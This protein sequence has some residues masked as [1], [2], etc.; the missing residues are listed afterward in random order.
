[1]RKLRLWFRSTS[2]RVAPFQRACW[3][4]WHQG[5][6]G[7]LIAPTGSGKT[8][9]VLG[10]PLVNAAA[11][12]TGPGLRLLWITPLRALA[13]DTQRQISEAAIGMGLD[14][15]VLRRTGDSGGTERARVA[16]GALEALVTTPESL[17]L[18]LSHPDIVER[19][20][21]VETIVVDE[22]HELLGNKRGV[23]LQLSLARIRASKPDVRVWG[24]SATIGNPAQALRVLLGTGNGTLIQAPTRRTVELVT[25]LPERAQRFP[26]GGHLGLAQLPRVLAAINA[27]RTTLVFTNTRSQAELWHQALSA[28]WTDDGAQLAIHHGSIDRAERERVETQLANGELRAVV[29]TSSLDLGVDFAAVDLV[30][31][32]GSPRS[33]ARLMQRAG[34]S[35]HRPGARSRMLLVPTHNLEIAEAAAL[36][37]AIADTVIESRVPP[38][39]SLDVLAQHLVTLSVAGGFDA[40]QVLREIRGTEAFASLTLADY[41]RVLRFITHGGEALASY[42]QFQRVLQDDTGRYVISSPAHARL[43]RFSIGTIAS[44]PSVRLTFV[45]GA[46]L[47][48]VEENFA[49]RLNPGDRFRFAGRTLE[50]V[51]L[52]DLVAQ[53]RLSRKPA[54][55]VPRWLGGRLPLSG[56][57]AAATRAQLAAPASRQREMRAL[58]PMLERQRLSS[59]LPQA[60]E[61]LVEVVRLREGT[62]WFLYPFAGRLANEGLAAVLTARLAALRPLSVTYSMN[63][64]GLVLHARNLPPLDAQLLRTLLDPRDLDVALANGINLAELARRRFRDIAKIAG[65]LMPSRPGAPRALRQ[66]QASSGLLFDVLSEHDPTHLLLEQAHREVREESLEIERLRAALIDIERGE[67]VLTHPERLTPFAFPLWAESLRGH[68]THEDWSARLARMAESLEAA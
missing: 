27:A 20:R 7:L 55:S 42:P 60:S 2:K 68:L 25:A 32:I 50:L 43:H 48:E 35:G 6:S 46:T 14:W 65:L 54:N 3:E 51:R 36:R 41:E 21:L 13:G 30:V 44:D 52:R 62:F 38:G 61:L 49:A 10:G 64:Y 12:G 5:S 58:S 39:L 37:G 33:V 40:A 34:R 59:H 1:M 16:R 17:S 18:M 67:L 4:A 8:L 26:W 23:L 24:L 15:R 56:T 11:S 19:M 9:A 28:V 29:A 57:L 31:Q 45:R 66:L 47:G 53:V 63:D 22:W